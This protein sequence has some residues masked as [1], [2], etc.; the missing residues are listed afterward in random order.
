[1]PGHR[2]EGDLDGGRAH[3]AGRLQAFDETI[4]EVGRV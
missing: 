2:A 3:Q 4:T 1:M